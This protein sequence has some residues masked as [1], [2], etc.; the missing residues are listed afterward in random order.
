M[1]SSPLRRGEAPRW[2]CFTEAH[3]VSASLNF[4]GVGQ[5]EQPKI[6]LIPS[7]RSLCL[8]SPLFE[9]G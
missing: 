3:P 1:G 9:M 8:S 4:L 2:K 6:K 5:G 7:L